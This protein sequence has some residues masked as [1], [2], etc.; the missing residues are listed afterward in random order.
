MMRCRAMGGFMQTN[1]PLAVWNPRAALRQAVPFFRALPHLEQAALTTCGGETLL[2]WF[3]CETGEL[4][5][6][7]E[8]GAE[9]GRVSV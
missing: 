5:A 7:T 2:I 1:S 8:D 4:V 9:I 3:D 6:E